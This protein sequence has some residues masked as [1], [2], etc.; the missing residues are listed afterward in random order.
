MTIQKLHDEKIREI[1]EDYR[2]NGYLVEVEPQP[3][4]IPG[5]DRNLRPDMLVEKDGIH[6]VVEVKSRS[7]L[8][9]SDSVRRMA[10]AIAKVPEWKFELII[11]DDSAADVELKPNSE[12]VQ[13]QLAAAELVLERGQIESAF[14]MVWIALEAALRRLAADRGIEIGDISPNRLIRELSFNG[15]LSPEDSV[16][17]TRQLQIRNQA[18]H[19]F[20]VPTLVADDVNALREL[21]LKVA[22]SVK[23]HPAAA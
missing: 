4:S 14:M 10:D 8:R 12:T 6:I 13:A 18:V 11:L 5:F 1:A 16:I 20:S 15:L 21:T 22:E 7:A 3:E 19:G 9:S 23:E 17:F 2:R